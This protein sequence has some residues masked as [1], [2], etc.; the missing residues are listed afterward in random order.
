[1][2]LNFSDLYTL[3][4]YILCKCA[5]LTVA[6]Y[7]TL[8]LFLQKMFLQWLYGQSASSCN[9]LQQLK[10]KQELLEILAIKTTRKITHLCKATIKNYKQVI[11]K[12]Y[13]ASNMHLLQS[14]SEEVFLTF[15]LHRCPIFLLKATLLYVWKPY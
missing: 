4:Y 9:K 15:L 8:F 5:L 6:A 3:N 11:T 13:N 14:S 7:V 10:A 1:M 12:N 2:W